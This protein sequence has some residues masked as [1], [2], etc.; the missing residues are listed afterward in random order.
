MTIIARYSGT[1]AMCQSTRELQLHSFLLSHPGPQSLFFNPFVSAFFFTTYCFLSS[2]DIDG[3][4]KTCV[5]WG[6]GA[7]SLCA[8]LYLFSTILERAHR[9]V[10]SQRQWM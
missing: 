3:L 8:F 7:V 4:W 10:C 1:M 9:L 2:V 6:F 5:K